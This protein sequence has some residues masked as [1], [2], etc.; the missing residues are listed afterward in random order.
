MLSHP[1][2]PVIESTLGPTMEQKNLGIS[3]NNIPIGDSKE[4]NIQL[5]RSVNRFVNRVRWKIFYLFNPKAKGTRKESYGLKS[6]KAAPRSDKYLKEFE[7]ELH[8]LVKEVKHRDR[9]DIKSDF[10]NELDRKVK[11]IKGSNKVL[12]AADKSSNYYLMSKEHHDQLLLKAI[13][14]D[15]K[16]APEGKEAQVNKDTKAISDKLEI[17]DRVFKLEL[18]QSVITVKD[19]KPEFL[20]HTQTRLIN[21][22]KNHLGR[23][24]K[25][26]LEEL[27]T[28]VR[29]KAGLIQWKNTDTT[30][31]WFKA[32]EEK[33]TL[34]FLQFDID[35]YYPSISPELLDR[36]LNWASD[37][38]TI[39]QADREL[40]HVTKDSLLFDRG[41]AWVKKGDKS[42]DVSMGSWDG[43]E[44]CDLVGLFLLSQLKHLP[45]TLGLYRDDGLGVSSL[46]PKENEA[47]KK[48]I[49]DVFKANG[50]GI[51]ISVNKKAVSF[52]NLTINLSDA[53]F[54][55]FSKE[56]HV[57]LY[58]HKE[59]NH[60]PAVTKCI[61]K[62]VGQRLS[63]NSS[64]QEMFDAAKG[65][66]QEQLKKAGYNEELKFEPRE[67][68][69]RR[70]RRRKR[71]ICW[72]NPP[73]STASPTTHPAC[74]KTSAWV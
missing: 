69:T 59:S 28:K 70:R 51:T 63:A 33:Q 36:A 39:S 15:Y 60:P 21:P 72:F 31:S 67:E 55:D 68:G 20:N 47:L 48:Q 19:H 35:S 74:S 22:T 13:H 54:R 61:V 25:V 5:I 64:S 42:F 43:A 30:I 27:N 57:P 32:L 2:V 16:K 71:D 14:K 6:Q 29:S 56:N 34:S 24:S 7:K 58:V 53:S 9:W 66:Y 46:K 73:M 49:S 45:A 18:K 26:K 65:L 37:L 52:L 3:T 62:G 10:L 50:L 12:V 38:V 40:F 11:V 17:S 8:R 41:T 44:T 23:V 4:Y 1:S